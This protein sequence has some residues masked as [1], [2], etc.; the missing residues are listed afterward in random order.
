MHGGGGVWWVMV[1]LQ[2]HRL[3]CVGGGVCSEEK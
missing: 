3:K 1:R 2:V